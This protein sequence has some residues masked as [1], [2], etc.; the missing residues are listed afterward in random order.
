M[1]EHVLEYNRQF[2]I[3][4]DP[5]REL[6]LA[7]LNECGKRKFICTTLR[8]TKLPFVELYD[9]E[10]CAKFIAD[11]LEY[12]ELPEPDKLPTRI[13][14]PANVLEWQIGDSF[15][16][17]IVLCSLLIGVGYNAYVV[18][19]TAPKKITC[20]DESLEEVPFDTTFR[21]KGDEDLL[22]DEDPNYD[23]DE[24]LMVLKEEQKQDPTEDF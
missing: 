14:S 13:P 15:D 6:L 24:E 16:F 8:P 7:P 4:Y 2:K 22:E 3:I 18:Y 17:A 11:Y 5:L 10:T 9:W 19:G 20:H 1:L 21:F 12:E 23:K